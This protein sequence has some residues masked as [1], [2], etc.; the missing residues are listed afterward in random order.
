MWFEHQ[1]LFVSCSW[2]AQVRVS[3]HEF[4]FIFHSFMTGVA[5]EHVLRH[6]LGIDSWSQ[7]PHG[8]G[9]AEKEL[10]DRRVTLAGIFLC[11]LQIKCVSLSF[12]GEWQ[13]CDDVKLMG[14]FPIKTHELLQL[15]LV[16]DIFRFITRFSL[17]I[18]LQVSVSNFENELQVYL[19]LIHIFM[20]HLFYTV[21][22]CWYMLMSTIFLQFLA[23]FH[24]ICDAD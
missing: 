1:H 11:Q 5:S 20:L 22:Y 16:S 18:F 21:I 6:Y 4:S 3:L 23:Y 9:S 15:L 13:Q 19:N 8:Y 2:C 12:Y 24:N 17:T 10:W 14:R 7:R